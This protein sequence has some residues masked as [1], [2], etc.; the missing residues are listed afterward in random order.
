[1]SKESTLLL[2]TERSQT[3][4]S[5]KTKGS[6]Y[7]N[8]NDNLHTF[9][10]KFSNW[11]G[12]LKLQGTLELYP[13]NSS[14]WFTLKDTNG[15]HILFNQ[16]SSDY[17]DTYTVNSEGRFVWIRAVGTTISGEIAEIRYIY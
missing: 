7:H 1:M 2:S 8:Q 15:D 6:G 9:Q 13:N 17:D 5:E 12:E 10:I 16:D 3:F 14:D 11:Q 4:V